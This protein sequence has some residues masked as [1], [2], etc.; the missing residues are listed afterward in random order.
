MDYEIEDVIVEIRDML[1]E[2][3]IMFEYVK[4]VELFDVVDNELF[5]DLDV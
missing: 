3:E 2:L 1:D 4:E 5:K